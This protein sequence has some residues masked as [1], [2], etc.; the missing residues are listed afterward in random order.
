VELAATR[1]AE[2]R[3]A[4]AVLGVGEVVFLGHHDGELQVTVALKRELVRQLRRVRPELVLTWCPQRVLAA[5]IGWSHADH[6]AV[7]EATL[8]AVYPEALMPRIHP[9]LAEEGLRPHEVTEVWFPALDDADVYVDVSAV[10]DTKMDA[11]WC[12]ASQNGEAA[13]DR[14]RMFRTH[15]EPPLAEA[16]ARIGVRHA[17]RFRRVPV[18]G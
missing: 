1:A 16:G 2:Q 14:G 17:E 11:V 15:I 8:Q 4:A 3:G 10:V 13:G 6:L 18:R 9:D 5:P 12:H 7:G